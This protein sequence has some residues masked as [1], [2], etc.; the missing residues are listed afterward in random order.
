MF[1]AWQWLLT[2]S[3]SPFLLFFC[4]FSIV[5]VHDFLLLFLLLLLSSCLLLFSTLFSSFFSSFFC[6]FFVILS[7]FFYFFSYSTATTSSLQR[8]NLLRGSSATSAT[9]LTSTTLRTV[10]RKCRCQTPL[11]TP[12]T[13][14][15]RVRSGP[16]A[17]S[18]RSLG[19]GLTPVTMTRPFKAFLLCFF[20]S[21]FLN[22][23]S[24]NHYICT[25][26]WI[27]L[28]FWGPTCA[29]V[30]TF[31]VLFFFFFS[32]KHLCCPHHP[33]SALRGERFGRIFPFI[34]I[35]CYTW[36]N[37][38]ICNCKWVWRKKNVW[39]LGFMWVRG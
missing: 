34:Q 39:Y 14:A 29:C 18:V 25:P 27:T 12:P 7:F 23:H 37:S 6:F 3:P 11:H 21:F 22:P 5:F 32:S 4:C 2:I 33:L 15:I 20:F 35:N 24:H 8:R 16:T 26:F 9:A 10:L 36:N 19:T 13:M 1:A 38:F 31:C 28:C 17:T 30:Y